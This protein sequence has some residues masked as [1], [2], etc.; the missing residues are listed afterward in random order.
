MG[1]SPTQAA[2]S[3]PLGLELKTWRNAL[4]VVVVI[5]TA[6]MSIQT[7]LGRIGSLEDKVAEVATQAQVDQDKVLTQ[8]QADTHETQRKTAMET[9]ERRV[10]ELEAQLRKQTGDASRRYAS[11]VEAVN[12][13]KVAAARIEERLRA[14]P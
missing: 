2:P 12:A 3:K 5:V 8:L 6:G 11:L 7:V 13:M 4:A 9:L 14:L 1:D 10:S